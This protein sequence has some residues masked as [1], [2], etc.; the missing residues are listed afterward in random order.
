MAGLA[1]DLSIELEALKFLEGKVEPRDGAELIIGLL[2][3]GLGG[4]KGALW[5]QEGF[6]NREPSRFHVPL[7]EILGTHEAAKSGLGFVLN[8]MIQKE[9]I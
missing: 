2:D 7:S 4:S 5:R 3:W 1:L 9:E 6:G 8:D